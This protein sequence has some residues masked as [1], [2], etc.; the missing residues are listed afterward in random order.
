MP[1]IDMPQKRP[2]LF[3]H[4]S[5]AQSNPKYPSARLG[6]DPYH[7]L[8]IILAGRI[9]P[10]VG[11][12]EEFTVPGDVVLYPPGA[13]YTQ[14]T[15]PQA[16][17]AC[18]KILFQWPDR[19]ASVPLVVNDRHGVVRLLAERLESEGVPGATGDR[20]RVQEYYLQGLLAE[21]LRLGQVPE[22][23]LVQRLRGY[24]AA[25]LGAPI[26][27]AELA[28]HLGLNKFHLIRKFKRLTGDTPL[29]EVR[30]L[31]VEQAWQLVMTTDLPV[32]AIA[33]DV[34][35][36]G[37]SHLLRLFRQ[38]YHVRIRDLRASRRATK[39]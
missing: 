8:L 6:A 27:L 17:L 22:P 10:W 19:P 13:R 4:T 15:D 9:R 16:P 21:F 28:H 37:P 35:L 18:V 3:I 1:E 20:Q 39:G 29:A 30:R 12:R 36:G 26:T 7:L 2:V 25:H 34:G 32:K 38:Q 14:E 24:A 5:R 11:V 23:E 31:R 33:R